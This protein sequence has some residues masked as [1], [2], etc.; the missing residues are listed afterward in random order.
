MSNTWISASRLNAV[1]VLL[2]WGFP[3]GLH[4]GCHTARLPDPTALTTLSHADARDRLARSAALRSR[5]TGAVKARLPGLQGV[6]LNADLDVAAQVPGQL[7]VAVKSFF[8]A[9]AQVF[10]TDGER[11][12]LYDA[13][14]GAPVFY[15]GTVSQRALEKVLQLPLAPVDAVDLVLGRPPIAKDSRVRVTKVQPE[16]G[17]YEVSV[18]SPQRGQTVLV[19]R[20]ADDVVVEWRAFH[21]DGRPLLVARCEDL[22]RAGE[23]TFAHRITIEVMDGEKPRTV[24]LEAKDV[25][26]NGTVVPPEAFH[27]DPPPGMQA[28]PL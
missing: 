8:E 21:P 1:V 22:R 14:S 16:A 24:V 18:E 12:T 26:W 9:P 13:T 4:L 5:M 25:V 15:V 17:L 3:L 23:L 2:L 11:V 10:V 27:L 28:I 6:V 19:M 20:A 7:S